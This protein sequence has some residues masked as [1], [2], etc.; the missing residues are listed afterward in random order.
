[1]GQDADDVLVGTGAPGFRFQRG[2]CPVL[3]RR[4]NDQTDDPF[5]PRRVLVDVLCLL[6]MYIYVCLMQWRA[7][8]GSPGPI[9]YQLARLFRASNHALSSVQRS[10]AGRSES[11]DDAPEKE[12]KPRHLS[13]VVSSRPPGTEHAS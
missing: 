7:G 2:P 5:P 1:M 11:L 9:P 13:P 12:A 8:P 3:L 10:T 6:G 4:V